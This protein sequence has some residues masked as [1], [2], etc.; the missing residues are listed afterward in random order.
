MD[1]N[2]L[3]YILTTAK[4]DDTGQ[5]L[6]VS[7]A[8]Y[9]FTIHYRSGKQNVEA[10]ALSRIRWCHDDAI[11]VKAISARGLNADTMIRHPK[12]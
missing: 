7:L 6:V 12:R 1:N 2:P 8:N 10:D 3:T 4:L 9:D 5:R 11:I